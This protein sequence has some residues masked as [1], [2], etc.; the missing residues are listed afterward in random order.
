M[1]LHNDND[2]ML[3][4]GFK[5]SKFRIK[6]SAKAF[7]ILSDKLYK[8]KIRAVI[9]ELSCNAVDAHRMAGHTK[10]FTVVLPS[11]LDKRFVL[12]DFGPGIHPEDI[13]DVFTV[14]F[15]ST[16]ENSNDD[17]G[18][19]G[20]GCKS[21]FAYTDGFSVKT[22]HDGMVYVY[23]MF[24]NNGEPECALMHSAKSEE[25]TGVEI[26]VPTKEHDIK[27]WQMEAQY[28]YRSFNRSRPNIISHDLEIEYMPDDEVFSFSDSVSMSGNYAIMGGVVYPLPP[29]LVGNYVY[30]TFNRSTYFR[31]E[32]GELDIQP[33]REELSLDD[34]TIQAII[35]K[36]VNY[37]NTFLV[38]IQDRINEITERRKVIPFISENYA[39]TAK[40][41]IMSTM[42]WNGYSLQKLYDELSRTTGVSDISVY[43]EDRR[44]G[45]LIHQTT[46][47]SYCWRKKNIEAE[48]V[49]H[50]NLQSVVLVINDTGN[51]PTNY[52]R[53][54]F[55]KD[56]ISGRVLYLDEANRKHYVAKIKVIT[57]LFHKGERT[58]LKLSEFEE[59]RKE[60]L[61]EQK[62]L[63]ASGQV[64]EKRPKAPN[65]YH[66]V[67]EHGAKR[68]KDL[69]LSASEIK[70]LEGYAIRMF[71]TR[72]YKYSQESNYGNAYSVNDELVSRMGITEYYVIRNAAYS[73]ARKAG[74]LKCLATECVAF[75]KDYVDNLSAD[76]LKPSDVITSPYYLL[77]DNI[78]K[79]PG[80]ENSFKDFDSLIAPSIVE[81]FVRGMGDEKG[82]YLT[83]LKLLTNDCDTVYLDKI[84]KFKCEHPLVYAVCNS[85]I[86][87]SDEIIAD[88]AKL[89]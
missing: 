14:Y 16:K 55:Q 82:P 68:S 29:H 76:D 8:Y 32:I 43:S 5:S 78:K 63:K 27:D 21:P 66:I 42:N 7:Q 64:E 79:V 74:K 86:Y 6:A 17:I 19:F 80:F 35:D 25:P 58:I 13:E 65:A 47:T 12:R 49:L 10:D 20:L 72:F 89:K 24:L 4:S 54:M 30:N 15:E 38:K 81:T 26:I 83:N 84:T 37:E 61:R 31:F 36:C 34:Q 60:Y 46:T 59:E 53:A 67:Y 52:L 85:S 3:G 28:V 2:V 69:Y 18:G 87:L 44:F 88:L 48:K 50:W 40:S 11:A 57:D 73:Q 1:I 9:R 56:I 51:S 41:K 71:D 23:N 45:K 77:F 62:K 39:Y 33:S 75:V 22:Y 70:A